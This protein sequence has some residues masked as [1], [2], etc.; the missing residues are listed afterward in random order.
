MGTVI[1][2]KGSDF[3]NLGLGSIDFELEN[4]DAISEKYFERAISLSYSEKVA[5]DDF[6]KKLKEKSYFSKLTHI[7][8][9]LGGNADSNKVD[10]LN[11]ENSENDITFTSQDSNHV[12]KGFISYG[13]NY[14]ELPVEVP[15]NIND[16]ITTGFSMFVSIEYKRSFDTTPIY[17]MRYSAPNETSKYIFSIL[18]QKTSVG[19]MLNGTNS[20][21][22][23]GSVTIDKYPTTL[24]FSFEIEGSYKYVNNV[25]YG[26][27]K[28]AIISNDLGTAPSGTKINTGTETE[29]LIK[30][31]VIGKSLTSDELLDLETLVSG[32]NEILGRTWDSNDM[33][34]IW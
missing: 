11:A 17:A 31:I 22:S 12:K 14:G 5:V 23:N 8:P 34:P 4:A 7:Y 13:D 24:G 10:L 29:T 16:L 20:F 3:S 33:Q 19:C 28:R 26:N 27:T 9:F 15:T 6:V 25:S 1:I 18:C 30:T 21:T 32:L 2:S